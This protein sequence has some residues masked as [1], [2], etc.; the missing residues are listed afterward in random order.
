MHFSVPS[1]GWQL[2]WSVCCFAVLHCLLV[3]CTAGPTCGST[4]QSVGNSSCLRMGRA[5]PVPL[6]GSTLGSGAE[7]EMMDSRD[8]FSDLPEDVRFTLQVFRRLMSRYVSPDITSQC[9]C[10]LARFR[11]LDDVPLLIAV[12]QL[13]ARQVP[14]LVW[15]RSL[16]QAEVK[17][18]VLVESS[19]LAIDYYY[20]VVDRA[21]MR[22]IFQPGT[23]HF[24]VDG[25]LVHHHHVVE[26]I[27]ATVIQID[28][29]NP[30]SDDQYDV[31]F[32]AAV[33]DEVSFMQATS[34]I[35]VGAPHDPLSPYVLSAY[36]IRSLPVFSWLH[37]WDKKDRWSM[38]FQSTM[39]DVARPIREQVLV[40]WAS[41]QVRPDVTM[42]P[43]QP[44][45]QAMHGYHPVLLLLPV[46]REDYVGMFVTVWTPFASF[47][48]TFLIRTARFLPVQRLFDVL[49]QG[50]QCVW[51]NECEVRI[52]A[53]AY[54]WGALVPVYSGINTELHEVAPVQTGSQ[55]T[56]SDPGASSSSEDHDWPAEGSQP[57]NHTPYNEE[58]PR[59][60]TPTFGFSLVQ[61]RVDLKRWKTRQHHMHTGGHDS[62]SERPLVIGRELEC[63]VGEPRPTFA[64]EAKKY[65]PPPG[66][67]KSKAI[68]VDFS[69]T[70]EVNGEQCHDPCLGNSY[71][72]HFKD[73]F[74][75]L[76]GA[77]GRSNP[78]AQAVLQSAV[79]KQVTQHHKQSLEPCWIHTPVGVFRCQDPVQFQWK[80]E[81][82]F[83]LIPM[84][85]FGLEH[86]F[87]VGDANREVLPV[88]F[89]CLSDD[90]V[91]FVYLAYGTT[92]SEIARAGLGPQ[93]SEVL[94]AD[95][96]QVRF[97][98]QTVEFVWAGG[99]SGSVNDPDMSVPEQGNG[100]VPVILA[101]QHLLWPSECREIA[102][103]LPQHWNSKVHALWPKPLVGLP[104]GIKVHQATVLALSQ[105]QEHR[106]HMQ[107]C[108]CVVYVDGSAGV[109]GQAW[110]M[111]VTIRGRYGG[112]WCETFE[113]V[114]AAPQVY[115]P[116]DSCWIGA[117]HKD[118]VDAELA[119]AFVAIAYA[120]SLNIDVQV[121]ARPDLQFSCQLLDG[122]VAPSK[123]RPLTSLVANLGKLARQ[124][125][126][127]VALR[128]EAHAG[129]AW[130]EL[131]DSV[132][133][134]AA[135]HA[136]LG[137]PDIAWLNEMATHQ[138][139][140]DWW[141]IL[142]A[143]HRR[144]AYPDEVEGKW[145]IGVASKATCAPLEQP[146]VA[147]V[148]VQQVSITCMTYNVLSLVDDSTFDQW[149]R[150][151][152]AKS[153]RMD[154]Q[155]HT[156]G[157]H[158]A[159][160]Q[161]ARTDEGV[162][163]T[164]H[165]KIF[166]AGSAVPAAARQYGCEI[167]FHRTKPWTRDADISFQHSNVVV[168]HQDP[169]LLVVRL[170]NPLGCWVFLSGHAPYWG[171]AETHERVVDW[172][173]S[174]ALVCSQVPPHAKVVAF[175]DCNATLGANTSEL[176]SDWGAQKPGPA[177][178]HCEMLLHSAQ[179]A[180]PATFANIH[181]GPHGTWRHPSG[182][183]RRIDHICV[184][185]DLLPMAHNSYVWLNFDGG[186]THDDH[187]PVVLE[188]KGLIAAGEHIPVRI[189]R[190]ACADPCK[191]E[192]FQNA[193]STLAI[194]SW[195]VDV[196]EHAAWHRHQVKNLAEAIFAPVKAVN[197]PIW[198]SVDTRICIAW[199]RY[200]L[201]E[202]RRSQ[203][204]TW[205]ASLREALKG[206]E[207]Q[208]RGAC[209]CDRRAFFDKAIDDLNQAGL[210]HDFK[211][212]SRLLAMLGKK[213]QKSGVSRT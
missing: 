170:D 105:V 113:G 54:A 83:V 27:P 65:L 72:S 74:K 15:F 124:K 144:H 125:G 172:W 49:V 197:K 46:D 7:P 110:G 146:H 181:Q 178:T 175:L 137:S 88:A 58:G 171:N 163:F 14:Q 48:G 50:N 112:N 177:T 20:K 12:R 103:D 57:S 67:G 28:Q 189:D 159:G 38:V 190:R 32:P 101:L 111:V 155:M 104:D 4:S 196:D 158:V 13:V 204:A 160:F 66:N 31:T 130:N 25:A 184:H 62:Y 86:G 149:G 121:V 193:L 153:A 162:S 102:M 206:A 5:D 127:A 192:Q 109:K 78:F 22:Y 8:D 199:K 44:R 205:R 134:Y 183:W 173:K 79:A 188:L 96:F 147:P 143:N 198:M 106:A 36:R 211:E 59:S 168:L 152:G 85:L 35:V 64:H 116:Q 89:K 156:K 141:P 154:H 11:F 43:M 161:E 128:V 119:A 9:R 80:L 70:I 138:Q 202:F 195:L 122:L 169:R 167:W 1:P 21:L 39:V 33:Q 34:R 97:W 151:G 90:K 114:C 100:T 77:E 126:L 98:G 55:S 212:V 185:K 63:V 24:R 115:D 30:C 93:D 40:A 99:A 6:T 180:C 68:R 82:P 73:T 182:A 108:Q 131:A 84:Q 76:A 45:S 139:Y 129:Q 179:L 201:D 120:L 69:A 2:R 210:A 81:S 95:D 208:V 51:A 107:D 165:Y 91:C 92:A 174:L 41:H 10:F 133:A 150:R 135:K 187:V 132:A 140:L 200:L 194:P 164:E 136:R 18:I 94:A 118:N 213:K 75:S 209:R 16:V 56:C 52:G 19:N 53:E 148:R 186:F 23:Y 142:H 207:K 26:W 157:I 145:Q 203:D 87:V 29:T 3:G 166:S 61:S 191:V 47:Q 123:D 117:K 37:T 42:Y 17:K 176:V 71:M 60:E